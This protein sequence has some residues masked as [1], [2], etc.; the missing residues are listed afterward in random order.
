MIQLLTNLAAIGCGLVVWHEV[1]DFGLRRDNSEI[2]ESAPVVAGVV[3]TLGYAVPEMIALRHVVVVA[4]QPHPYLFMLR[5]AV[6]MGVFLMV[7]LVAI[8]HAFAADPDRE[9]EY[10]AELLGPAGEWLIER[11]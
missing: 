1:R 6:F 3:V 7:V 9:F 8:E 10:Q 11:F 2:A 4:S 5:A